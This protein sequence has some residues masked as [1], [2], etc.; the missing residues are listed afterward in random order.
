M[1][2]GF[3]VLHEAG[4]HRPKAQA[5][6][7][8]A[9]AQQDP[10]LP[11]GHAAEHQQRVLVMDHAAVRADVARQV[12]AVGDLERDGASRSYCRNSNVVHSV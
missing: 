2:Q 4:G 6:L 1:L 10:A 7:D 11:F 12:I 3:A 9:P 5:R 8:G